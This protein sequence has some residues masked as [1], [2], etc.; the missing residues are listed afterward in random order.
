MNKKKLTW[1]GIWTI[2]KN[3]FK[4]FSTDKL[5]KLAG[6]LS[7]YT[8][9]S[10]GPLLIVII[11]LSSIFFEK[12]VVE[13]TI[14][15]QLASFLGKDTALQLQQI[16]ANASLKGKNA[17]PAVIG[18][19]TL[20]IG[21]TTVFSEIQDSINGIWGIKPK[22]KK[23]WLKMLKNRLLSFS[24]IVSLGFLLVVSLG[25]T[26]LIDIFSQRLQQH[27]PDTAVIVFYIINQLFTVTV[28]SIIFGVIFKVLPDA[29]IRWKDVS[30]GA[31]VT[32]LLFMLGKFG[33]SI[34][35]SK[36]AVGSTYG[37][38][39]ALVILIVWTYYSSI[40]LYFGAEFTKHYALQYGSEIHPAEYAVS[41]KQ[42]EVETP[43]ASLQE[44]QKKV[45]KLGT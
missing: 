4:D 21:A 12:A 16:I 13:G 40:I 23:G 28:L 9:F 33:I 18:F 41:L 10:M 8:I 19:I 17:F 15:T 1:R 30:A 32:A 39:G 36:A 6:S 29:T 31:L 35:I 5:T 45:E 22:P 42:V 27:F 26:S 38:A 43:N 11:F 20:L 2:V 14:Y 3:S 34:Y 37:A 25:V 44:N 24:V 7:Y